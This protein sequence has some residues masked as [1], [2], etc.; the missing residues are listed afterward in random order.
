MI[1]EPERCFVTI[2]RNRTDY[3]H[4]NLFT[5][6][7]LLI[8][9]SLSGCRGV[10]NASLAN[11]YSEAGKYDSALLSFEAAV[12]QREVLSPD[13][14]IKAA[15]WAMKTKS[16]NKA[17]VLL[18]QAVEKGL[19]CYES[20]RDMPEFENLKETPGWKDVQA[21]VIKNQHSKENELFKRSL[22]LIE[23]NIRESG[24]LSNDKLLS[25]SAK[26]LSD[27]LKRSGNYV[28]VRN[29]GTSY[30]FYADLPWIKR[31]PF[32]VYVPKGY[33]VRKKYPTV[34]FMHGASN[35]FFHSMVA[36]DFLWQD[37]LFKKLCDLNEFLIIQPI[38]D[39]DKE[40]N[41]A[42]N[43]KTYEYLEQAIIYTK[44][45]FHV[46]DDAV[47]AYGH[48]DG[49]RGAFCMTTLRPSVLA[50]A[51]S[52]NMG[53]SLIFNSIFLKNAINRPQYIVHSD[54]D[55][56]NPVQDTEN[57]VALLKRSGA[58]VNF[59]IFRG[60][61][62]E[63]RHL[64]LAF[65]STLYFLRSVRRQPFRK[66]IYWQT[67]SENTGCD[68]IKIKRMVSGGSPAAWSKP[69]NFKIY[70]KVQKSYFDQLLYDETP[71]SALEASF[72]QNT[73]SI[74]CSLVKEA[75]L[76]ISE[77]M[78]D[79]LKPVRVIVNGKTVFNRIVPV[80]QRYMISN[81]RRSR[82]KTTLWVNRITINAEEGVAEVSGDHPKSI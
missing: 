43:S 17:I 10:S 34:L 71:H 54:L 49:G 24:D 44:M 75:E 73:F 66:N 64:E 14:Y 39:R 32:K 37:I 63:D 3:L 70:D 46:D 13:D 67:S 8:F 4:V 69:L 7:S 74:R 30:L 29:T 80:D 2:M 28:Q 81:F 12:K 23:N 65:D 78:V 52:L 57:A 51:V 82:D 41:W 6:L 55:D 27:T 79:L 59:K 42:L 76:F 25:L 47:F 5:C 20:I 22:N 21:K 36:D 45:M 35:Y 9:F 38:C 15:T 1:A 61:R 58:N 60:Y 68:W 19:I 50:G 11:G 53:P 48:S 72:S 77:A 40:I 62:H 26:A 56:I 33:D 16:D 18:N 31:L